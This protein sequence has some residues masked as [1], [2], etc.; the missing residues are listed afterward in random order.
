MNV[1]DKI[2]KLLALAE[3][4]NENE[5]KSALLKAREL[6]AQYK[7]SPDEIAREKDEAVKNEI[8][9]F[10]FTKMTNDWIPNLASIIATHY[11]CKVYLS[12]EKY[13]KTSQIGLIG[14]ADDFDI[15]KK[16][17]TY[18][19]ECVLVKTNR[20]SRNRDVPPSRRRK[21]CNAYGYGFCR[22][23][24][25][26]YAEQE[27]AHQEWG[28]VMAV[29]QPVSDELA[30]LCG[31]AKPKPYG[32]SR[33]DHESQDYAESGYKAGKS[34]DPGHRVEDGR[35]DAAALSA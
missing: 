14:L 29:P 3:S 4:P 27:A 30:S 8:L 26:A 6:M 22:G 31:G 10:K 24:K 9:S 34:F 25:V 33:S 1:K 20:I 12:S 15:C 23:L 7:L 11:C 18:A 5:A 2:A 19:I 17:I 32:N 13:S 35:V 28:L 21:D 16:I